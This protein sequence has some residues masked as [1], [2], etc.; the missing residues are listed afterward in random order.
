MEDAGL[1]RVQDMVLGLQKDLCEGKVGR[2]L[3]GDFT[4][5]GGLL[6]SS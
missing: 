6:P 4:S 5:R 1:G 2:G 3:E